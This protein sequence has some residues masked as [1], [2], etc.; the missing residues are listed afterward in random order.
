MAAAVPPP[1][2]ELAELG[3]IIGLGDVRELARTFLANTPR[4]IDELANTAPAD[5]T[6]PGTTRCHLAAHN[7]KS[8]SRLVGAHALSTLAATIENR[9][10]DHG[11][12]PTSAEIDRAREEFARFIPP[13]VRFAETG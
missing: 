6:T 4:L 9:L 5:P 3:R 8:T 1:T 2:P 7:L 12:A 11:L 10:L 13:L